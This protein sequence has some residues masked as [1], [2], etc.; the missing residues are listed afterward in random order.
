MIKE[1]IRLRKSESDQIYVVKTM[2]Q[3]GPEIVQDVL[4][5]KN[6]VRSNR[7]ERRHSKKEGLF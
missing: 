5:K 7:K 4:N 1:K 6:Q 2:K 3:A